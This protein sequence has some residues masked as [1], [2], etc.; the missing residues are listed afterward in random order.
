MN[1]SSLSVKRPVTTVMLVLIVVLIGIVSVTKIPID[2]YPNIEIPVAIVS[3]SYSNVAPEEIETLVTRPIEEAVGTVSNLDSIR[4]ITTEGASIVIVQFKFGTDMDFAALDMR[5]KVDLVAGFLPEGAS[6]PMVMQIDINAA[7]V[8]QMSLS[9][10]DVANLQRYADDVIKPAIERVEGVAS[11]DIGGGYDNYV[12]IQVDTEQLNGYGLSIDS[13]AG[14][15]ASENINLPA[16]SVN[17]GN[18]GLLI[19]TVGEFNSLEAIKDTPIPMAT[20]GIIR[21]SDIATVSI[22]NK[23][24]SSITSVD[25][26]QAVSVAVQKQSGVNTVAVASEVNKV[27][28]DLQSDSPYDIKVII[29]Q[30]EFINDSIAQV[31]TNG[32][33]G[34][35]LAV[36]ILLIFLRSFRSTI[37]IGISIPISIIATAVLLFFAD[38]TLNMMTLGGLALG[39]GMLVDN[40][41]VVLENIYRFVQEGYD[42]TEAAIKGAKE[43]AMAVTASTLT[44]V[45]VFLPMVFVEGITSIMFREFSL[46]VTFS[47]LSSLVVSLT[48]IPM[49]A[50]KM[51]VVDQFEGKHHETKFH[52]IGFFLDKFDSLFKGLESGYKKTLEWSLHH[53][54]TIV[55]LALTVFAGSLLSVSLIGMEFMPE[56]DEGTFSINVELEPGAKMEDT[57]EAMNIIVNRIIDIESIDYV[58][59]STQG[60]NFLASSTNSGS[61]SGVLVPLDERSVSVFDVVSEVEEKIQNI[62]GVITKVASSSSMGMMTGGS[63]ISIQVKGNNL[64]ILKNIGDEIIEAAQSVEGTRNV[65]SSMADPIP[66]F[67]ISLK[68]NDAARY[69][70]TTAQISSAVK[71]MLDGRTATRYKLDGTELDVVI[72]GDSRYEESVENLKQLMIQAP[73]GALVP[74]E[75]VAD[76]TIETGAV[77][78]NRDNQ[79]RYVTISADIFNRDLATIVSEIEEKVDEID[80]PRGYS[81]E[82][83]GQNEEMVEAFSDLGVAM[84]LAVLLVYMIIASQFESL[85]LPFIIMMTAPLAYSGGLIGLFLTNR[86]LNITSIIGFIMLSGIVVNNAIVLIDYIQTR[87]NMGEE[88]EEAILRAGPIRL[89]PILMTSLTTILG[90][91]P[92]ALGIG[93]GAEIQASMATVVIFGLILS[94]LLTLVFIPVVYTIFDNM[95]VKYLAKKNKKRLKKVEKLGTTSL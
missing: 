30:S 20:G 87:R 77:S 22:A 1:I 4:S 37:I 61:I 8:I 65:S 39:I 52:I 19:R 32:I 38:I 57:A 2:L 11:V 36:M 43:V 75:L 79:A 88:R 21:L 95:H 45:A 13:I 14:I 28:A 72:E 62:P 86:T 18:N 7:A 26:I 78:I 93:E 80:M 58:F 34:A 56:A 84:I 70:L 59:S 55:V 12:S 60:G 54:K 48:L 76:V 90:L 81:V 82:F 23:D 29:D 73:T 35:L 74:L 42:K 92:L 10:S 83:G 89:R 40:S 16:G 9:G 3:T 47:L 15:L 85:L 33:V 67:E 63:A 27:I 94:S 6:D 50:S 71:A 31:G 66:Q 46:T 64:E 69:G 51:L 91:V 44:T 25:G 41:V 49:M 24:Q 5:E 53:R 68:R 17:K